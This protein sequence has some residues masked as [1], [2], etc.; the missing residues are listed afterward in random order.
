MMIDKLSEIDETTSLEERL[1]VFA[2]LIEI[3]WS[4]AEAEAVTGVDCSID[5]DERKC[6]ITVLVPT[7]GGMH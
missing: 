4:H 7:A 5:L 1:D 2:C 6:R 3:G